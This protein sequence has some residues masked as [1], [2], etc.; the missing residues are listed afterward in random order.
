MKKHFGLF[1]THYKSKLKYALVDL[2]TEEL[3]IGY[4]KI[5]K[6]LWRNRKNYI[7]D[8]LR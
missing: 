6:V 3:Y 8:I 2:N 5:F 7:I 4:W 1:L